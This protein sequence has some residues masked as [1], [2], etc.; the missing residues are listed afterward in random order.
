M[1][2]NTGSTWWLFAL[3]FLLSFAIRVDRL[4]H[5]NPR[6]LVPTDDR[7][8]GAIAIS[9]VKTGEF[10]NPYILPTGPTAHLPPLPPLIDS[11]IYRAYGLTYR[12]GYNRAIF[13]I[14]TAS[15][16]YGLLP[17]FS[18]RFGTGRAA[19]VLGGLAGAISGLAT[20]ISRAANK[21]QRQAH[22]HLPCRNPEMRR[23]ASSFTVKSAV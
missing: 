7:E 8:L 6:H 13:I 1:D 12:A 20:A 16:L 21:P 2:R 9:L 5:M 17:W 11:L 14:I 3:I 23:S 18:E 4:N 19:G 10:A 15:V 22:R